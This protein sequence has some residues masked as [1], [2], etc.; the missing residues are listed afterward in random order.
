M[1]KHCGSVELETERLLLRPFKIEDIDIVFKTWMNDERVAKYTSWY[2]HNTPEE[3]R[4]F[5]E[6]ILSKNSE[7]DYN[8]IIEKD[9][10]IIGTICVCYSDENLEIAGIAYTLGYNYWGNG[11][12]TEAAKAVID[13][14]FTHI[15]YRKIIAGCDSEN[16][17]SAKVMEHIGMKR[18]AV[19]REQI[20]RKDGT[21]GDDFQYG[22]LKSEYK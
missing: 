20:K 7:R 8:W 3:T 13:L 5:I 16:I 11:Y 19:L 18:E 14:L 22:I 6:Y 1:L 12:M 4:G 9:G 15:G 21:W 10:E 17:G 2:A